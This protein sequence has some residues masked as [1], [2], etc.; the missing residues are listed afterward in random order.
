ML[1]NEENNLNKHSVK[2]DINSQISS[3]PTKRKYTKKKSANESESSIQP[4]KK[5]ELAKSAANTTPPI[6]TKIATA[7]TSTIHGQSLNISELRLDKLAYGESFSVKKQLVSVPV[8]KPNKGTF[9]R[10]RDGEDW[11][12]AALILERKEDNESYIVTREIAELV[13]GMVRAIMLYIA[14]DRKGN[15]QLVPVPLPDESGR[16]NNWHESLLQAVNIAKENWVRVVANMPAGCNDVMV[17]Q[18]VPDQPHWSEHSMEQLV[19]IAFRGK[20][21]TDVNHPL[22]QGLLGLA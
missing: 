18:N 3:I 22:I 17:A 13:P 12:F 2:D 6:P 8:K 16:R 11:Q 9:F 14:V 4:D 21:I 20:V 15:P 5:T 10:I 1:P 7:V 19:E